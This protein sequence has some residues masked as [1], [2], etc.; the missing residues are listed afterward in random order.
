MSDMSPV[1]IPKSDQINADDFIGGP[2]TYQIKGV[3]VTPG[4]EQPVSVSLVGEKR[5]WRPCKSMCRVMVAAWG[6]D[7]KA[8][9]GRSV[10]LY[11][12]PA[13]KW[14]GMEVGGIRISHMSHIERDILIQLTATRGKR[15]PHVVRPLAV[16]KRQAAPAATEPNPAEGGEFFDGMD[17]ALRLT[18]EEA[19]ELT[20]LATEAGMAETDDEGW[21]SY[22]RLFAAYGIDDL[23][24]LP[25]N[26]LAECKARIAKYVEQREA[27]A[28]KKTEAA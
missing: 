27:A 23:S 22:P 18:E 12:D 2:Q 14:G 10:T 28:R 11:R 17:S 24:N 1:I 4:T 16:A 13:V 6:P 5:V 15:S 20:R 8:Y 7:A 21:T 25:P 26:K 19:I 9:A 3:A